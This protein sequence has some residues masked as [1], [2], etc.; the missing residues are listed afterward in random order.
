MSDFGLSVSIEEDKDYYKMTDITRDKLP[1]KWLA[2]EC[3][4]DHK[5]SEASDVVSV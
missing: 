1:L 3:L 5:F 4:S 2:L